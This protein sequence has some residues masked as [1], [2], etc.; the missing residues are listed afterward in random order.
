LYPLRDKYEEKISKSKPI[1]KAELEE[2]LKEIKE[3]EKEV[4][5]ANYQVTTLIFLT[6][7]FIRNLLNNY[8][9]P[10]TDILTSNE[11]YYV[12]LG[13]I[14]EIDYFATYIINIQQLKF[15]TVKHAKKELSRFCSDYKFGTFKNQ[16]GLSFSPNSYITL[17]F[18][19]EI[20]KADSYLISRSAYQIIRESSPIMRFLY[21]NKIYFPLILIDKNMQEIFFP[22]EIKIQLID[23]QIHKKVALKDNA[24]KEF[25]KLIYSNL[26]RH[27]IFVKNLTNSQ[28]ISKYEDAYIDSKGV[29]LSKIENF[30]NYDP[31]TISFDL[32]K[33]YLHNLFKKNIVEIKK[34]MKEELNKKI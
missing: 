16:Q 34:K 25:V 10:E 13:I 1:N 27:L 15:T 8:N 33:E 17:R 14:N 19:Q 22:G 9:P 31:E 12:L 5:N 30:K 21:L 3:I 20:F 11:I 23:F 28:I 29:D 18:F 26:H 7:Q 32:D 24:T 2:I 6:K 4:T